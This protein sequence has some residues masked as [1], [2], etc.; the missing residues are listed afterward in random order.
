MNWIL[1]ELVAAWKLIAMPLSS[2][3][4]WMTLVEWALTCMLL[5]FCLAIV[6]PTIY[7]IRHVPQ[8]KPK[9]E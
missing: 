5:M 4:R 9:V 8:P 7:M 3:F 2:V 1:S 6:V